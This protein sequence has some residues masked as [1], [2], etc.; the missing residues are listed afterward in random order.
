MEKFVCDYPWTHFEVNNPDGTVSMCCD[1]PTPLGNVN[2]ATIGEIWNGPAYQ[3]IRRQMRD[4][5][6]QAICPP[7]CPV[8]A[9]GKAYQ[10]LDWIDQLDP[11][12]PALANAEL[13]QR[14]FAAGSLRLESLPRWMRFAYSYACNLDCYHC[15]QREDATA[16]RTLPD[17]FLAEAREMA[18][19]FQVIFPFGGEPFLFKPVSDFLDQTPVDPGCRYF[20]VT[21]ATLLNDRVFGMLERQRLGMIAVSLDAADGPTFDEL[22]RR[23]RQADWEALLANLARLQ[24]LR[25]R[26]G[27]VFTLSMTV[28]RRNHDQ[29]DRFVDLALGF[30]AE[31]LLV[32]VTNPYQ[33]AAFQRDF[34]H[35]SPEQ[36]ATMAAQIESALPK[37]RA[38][39]FHEAETFLEELRRCLASHRAGANSPLRFALRKTVRQVLAR[40][41]EPVAVRVM[42]YLRWWWYRLHQG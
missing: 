37:V 36:F 32:L 38:R 2:Q 20:F 19:L 8:M 31:P 14:E 10:R 11:A 3:A 35:F 9:G 28:N 4:Q 26:K 42:P 6:A 30:D 7:S 1:N 39:G 29:I 12:G 23:G 33:T 18:P 17:S 24:D 41:P 27:F 25:C 13:N 21:N 15:Y 16:H 40:L 5:G 34:L 22:R